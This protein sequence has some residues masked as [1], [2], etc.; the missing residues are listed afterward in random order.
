MLSKTLTEV[1]LHVKYV[2]VCIFRRTLFS[3]SKKYVRKTTG[4]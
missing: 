4:D 2:K 1:V 3:Y